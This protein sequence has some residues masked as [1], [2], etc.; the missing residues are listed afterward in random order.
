MLKNASRFSRYSLNRNPCSMGLI[1]SPDI[2]QE[3]MSTLMDGLE[4]V[5]TYLD[6]CIWL[7]SGTWE[8]HLEKLEQVLVRLKSA[9]LKVN[10]QKSF[11]G[12]SQL[13]YL[14]YWVTRDGIQLL[15]KKVQAI[16]DLMTPKTR[17]ELQRFIGMVNYYWD[18]WIHR[19]DILA[20]LTA[21]TSRNVQWAWTAEH[22]A[23][24][25]KAKGFDKSWSHVG[26]PRLL[27]TFW[28][29]HWR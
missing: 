26:F 20:P 21:L 27:A 17:K 7:T 14:G 6:D 23:T 12:Q 8:D 11:F 16:R 5:R 1:N 2:F 10:A 28:N 15:A 13:E 18:M 29:I 19:S 22:Q 24:F 3:K 25:V 9:G 4:F